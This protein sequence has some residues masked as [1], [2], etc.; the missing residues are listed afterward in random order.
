MSA[1]QWIAE[2][3]STFEKIA[4]ILSDDKP[5]AKKIDESESAD[6]TSFIDDISEDEES[7]QSSYNVKLKE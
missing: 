4:A 5:D 3:L 2:N 6:D 7:V 1:R